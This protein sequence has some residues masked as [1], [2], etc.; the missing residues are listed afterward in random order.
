M[1]Q[2]FFSAS[3]RPARLSRVTFV[4]GDV[5]HWDAAA[6]GAGEHDAGDAV[7]AQASPGIAAPL[8][9]RLGDDRPLRAQ[10]GTVQ[11]PQHGLLLGVAVHVHAVSRVRFAG[12]AVNDER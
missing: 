8:K 3:Y 7:V 5:L 2:S 12:E 1:S 4:R 11:V 6:V 10:K 9:L